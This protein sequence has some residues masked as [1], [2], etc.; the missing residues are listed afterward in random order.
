MI[1]SQF[2]GEL[3]ALTKSRWGHF[4]SRVTDTWDDLPFLVNM[5]E[6]THDHNIKVK[7]HGFLERIEALL[8]RMAKARSYSWVVSDHCERP[9][10]SKP[11]PINYERCCTDRLNS[12][13]KVGIGLSCSVGPIYEYTPL[14]GGRGAPSAGSLASPQ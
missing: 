3:G 7:S 4:V 10:A 8:N 6:E 11:Q 1:Y 2:W 5:S 12:Q 14:G 13:G 9:W